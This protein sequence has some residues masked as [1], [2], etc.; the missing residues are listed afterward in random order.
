MLENQQIEEV[1]DEQDKTLSIE[2]KVVWACEMKISRREEKENNGI[3]TTE[4]QTK[5]KTNGKM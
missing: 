1:M 5:G 3:E 4:N 2:I